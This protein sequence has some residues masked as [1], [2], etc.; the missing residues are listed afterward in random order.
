MGDRCLP[1]RLP[2]VPAG[3]GEGTGYAQNADRLCAA[4]PQLDKVAPA[5]G[6]GQRNR[7][8]RE[9]LVGGQIHLTHAAEEA[10]QRQRAAAPRRTLDAH[11]GIQRQQRHNRVVGRAGGDE[12]A[13]NCRPIPNLRRTDFPAGS[14]QRERPLDDKS[15]A[16]ALVVRNQRTQMERA[17]LFPDVSQARYARQIDQAHLVAV[18]RTVAR[19]F[20]QEVGAAGDKTGGGAVF[21]LQFQ[22]ICQCGGGC[23]K[24]VHIT[25]LQTTKTRLQMYRSSVLHHPAGKGSGRW[26]RCPYT[27][28]PSSS[29][30]PACRWR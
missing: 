7:D 9:H 2:V 10:R 14:R 3:A 23:A 26:R 30:R 25:P 22:G 27:R 21:R 4:Q 18:R 12:V 17:I 15:A 5:G 13:G 16:Y 28:V 6:S 1:C 11:A 24:A 20:D 29:R 19:Q 8:A